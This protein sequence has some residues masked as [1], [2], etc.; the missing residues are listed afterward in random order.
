MECHYINL[1]QATERRQSIEESFARHCTPGWSLSRFPAVNVP[2]IQQHQVSGQLRDSEKACFMSHRRLI[3]DQIGC[4]EPVL[5]LEDDARFGASTFRALDRLLSDLPADFEWDIIFTDV[6]IV[7][8]KF[9]IDLILLRRELTQRAE[10][11]LLD[12]AK[13]PFAGATAYLI[14]PQSVEKIYTLLEAAQPLD[15]P[16][17]LFLRELIWRERIKGHALF[18]FVTSISEWA[19]SSQIQLDATALT[20]LTWNTFRKLAWIDRDMEQV[21]TATRA[22]DHALLDEESR[23]LATLVAATTSSH[24]ILK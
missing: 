21:R 9:M 22:I 23:H 18:P 4:D 24:F 8:S 15:I 6:A 17:D 16:Y 10:T 7:D 3:G 19:E 2:Y 5:I 14:H 12:L 11:R 13:M 1:D 20:D